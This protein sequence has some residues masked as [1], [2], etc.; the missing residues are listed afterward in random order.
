MNNESKFD[1]ELRRAFGKMPKECPSADFSSRL[2]LRI[3]K[4]EAQKR[5]CIR[6]A[7]FVA[8]AAGVAC[9]VG[10]VLYFGDYLSDIFKMKEIMLSVQKMMA[11]S[12]RLIADT[13]NLLG[14]SLYSVFGMLAVAALILLWIDRLFRKVM[15]KK[16][17]CADLL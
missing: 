13:C 14:T 8:I 11:E 5:Q 12:G 1:N 16:N 3:R 2:M 9:A 10:V 4:L 6:L 17:D 15:G 7:R